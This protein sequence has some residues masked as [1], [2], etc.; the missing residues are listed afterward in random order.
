MS[1]QQIGDDDHAPALQVIP[2]HAAGAAPIEATPH[3][4]TLVVIPTYEEAL[5]IE[6]VLTRIR[7]EAPWVDIAVVDDN[8]P[9]GTPVPAERLAATRGQIVVLRRAQKDGLGAA[10]R[11]G[12]GYG[13]AHS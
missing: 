2:P 10:Y 9:H 3:P 4:S 8:S 7:V 12:F 1:V 13:L 11:T 5:N 6:F